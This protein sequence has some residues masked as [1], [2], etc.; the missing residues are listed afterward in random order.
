VQLR[1]DGYRVGLTTV[2]RTLHA[3]ADAGLVHVFH[4]DGED[5]YRHCRYGA[6]H[7]LICQR[8]HT[9]VERPT[10]ELDGLI[11]YLRAEADFSP[12]PQQADLVGVCGPCQRMAL[13]PAAPG[14]SGQ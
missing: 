6:H 12:D 10:E 1:A 2:Y 9:V 14:D 5:T 4:V 3:L 8:C 7:H 13:Q 11:D